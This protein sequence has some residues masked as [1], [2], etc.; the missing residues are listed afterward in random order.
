[1]ADLLLFTPS[2]K[3]ALPIWNERVSP[4]FDVAKRL[5]VF[6]VEGRI[7]T[8][9]TDHSL[10]GGGRALRLSA[11]GVDV[12]ICA[13]ISWPAE[14]ALWVAG[15]EVIPE[16][17]GPADEVVEAYLRGGGALRHFFSP[18]LIDHDYSHLPFYLRGKR[19]SELRRATV[20]KTTIDDRP[21]SDLK[22]AL[23]GER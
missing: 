12:L 22:P 2:M 17:C 1:M 13:A 23:E 21:V 19:R 6:E 14:A 5:R 4:V 3:V 11:L 15:V 8:G 7:I 9:T 20:G 16:V 18:V 10:D